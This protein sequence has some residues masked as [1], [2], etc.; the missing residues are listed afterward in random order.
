MSSDPKEVQ[1]LCDRIAGCLLQA[2][3]LNAIAFRSAGVKYANE[4]DFTSG[5]GASY[6]GGRWNPPGVAAIYASLDP[7]TAVKESY[8]EFIKYG[9]KPGNIQPR[10][11][12]GLKLNVNRV[13]DLTDAKIRKKLGFSRDRLT[14]E[15][16]Q[17]IQLF[18]RNLASPSTVEV[19]E[20]DKLPPHPTK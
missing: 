3:K 10:V 15:D 14:G 1:D 13:L 6:Y 17:A 8:Q 19:L 11:F 5:G 18:P 16:W 2:V 7:A 4:K 9:F 12:A 20:K